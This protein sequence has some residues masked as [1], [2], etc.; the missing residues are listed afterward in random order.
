MR[1]F[2]LQGG[3]RSPSPEF[4][5]LREDHFWGACF[6]L[7]LE[8]TISGEAGAS[9]TRTPTPPPSTVSLVGD[10]RGTEAEPRKMAKAKAK[11]RARARAKAKARAKK[12]N[13]KD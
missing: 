10:T 12:G 9:R 6:T 4:P 7:F 5:I 1:P 2:S 11:A 3:G 13:V 8:R